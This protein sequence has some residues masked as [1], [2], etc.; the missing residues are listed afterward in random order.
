M[1]LLDFLETIKD[2]DPHTPIH[3]LNSEGEEME[4]VSAQTATPAA[5]EKFIQIN[6]M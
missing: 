1:T 3:I 4:V 2:L 5:N 6:I